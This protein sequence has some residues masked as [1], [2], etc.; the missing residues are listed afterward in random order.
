MIPAPHRSQLLRVLEP[1][2]MDSHSDARDYDAM[3]HA[4]VN[5]LFVGELLD[6]W[7]DAGIAPGA[8]LLDLGT[9]TAQIPIALCQR[10]RQARVVAVDL[11]E[12]MLD[13]ARRNVARAG[14]VGRVTLARVD[15]K[16]LPYARESF[17]A[18]ISNSIV[19]H[20]PEPRGVLAEG[21]RVARRGGLVFV[22]DLARP[23]NDAQVA[24][25]VE[26]YAAD[27][28]DHQRQLFDDSLRAAL[29]IEEMRAL[30][31]ELGFDPATVAASS[32][33]HWTWHAIRS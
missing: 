13:V 4:A 15:A 31:I 27:C 24:A 22:R 18:V 14:L 30:V 2:A 3:D 33:R 26:T 6:A 7:S 10:D 11:A 9:G 5:R 28:N 25:L 29:S 23:A 8:P 16:H 20:I 19:H 1:E 32:D 17:A 12:S 21:V